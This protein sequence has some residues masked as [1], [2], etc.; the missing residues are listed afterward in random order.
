MEEID[1][2]QSSLEY[3]QS[4]FTVY[5]AAFI[6]IN[7]IVTYLEKSQITIG[8]TP[9]VICTVLYI[10]CI[11]TT[12][13]LFGIALFSAAVRDNAS[14][15]EPIYS[16]ITYTSSAI[17]SCIIVWRIRDIDLTKKI[18][19]AACFPIIGA[20]ITLFLFYARKRIRR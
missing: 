4:Y 19:Y 16:I 7:A 3:I 6:A 8:R 1:L 2:I 17:F 20:F 14:Y 5:V 13:F 15:N 11:T 9:F 12:E 10:I 18:A